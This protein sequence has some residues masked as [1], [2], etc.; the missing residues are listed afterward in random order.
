MGDQIML[1]GLVRHLA[2]SEKVLVVAQHHQEE[3]IK[4]MYRDEKNID[5]IFTGT[6]PSEIWEK[7]KSSG[8]NI[9]PLATYGVDTDFWKFVTEGQGK[10]FSNWAYGVY[11][12]AGINPYYMYSKFKVYRNEKNENELYEKLNLK[13]KEYIFI[14]DGTGEKECKE[15]RKDLF[16]VRPNIK[17]SSNIFNYLKIMENAKEIHCMNSSYAWLVNLFRIG[18]KNTNFFHTNLAYQSY[19]DR[20]V[21]IV[22]D[23]DLWTFVLY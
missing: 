17:D 5:F 13:G 3:S 18:N 22:F 10:I 7:A 11:I 1:N 20:D 14:H 23:E 21:K 15:C 6:E 2:E 12:Q 16:I 4:F 8:H 19:T 9:L